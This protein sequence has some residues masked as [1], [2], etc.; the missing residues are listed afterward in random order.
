MVP[1][2]GMGNRRFAIDFH[3][4]IVPGVD[5][6]ARSLE[7]SL[8]AVERMVGE[9][10]GGICTTPHLN[11]SITHNPVRL[12]QRLNKVN[13]AWEKVSSVVKDSFPQLELWS[14]YEIMLDIPDPNL[15][16]LRL[17]LAGTPFVL[18]EWPRLQIPPR[19]EQVISKI[20]ADGYLPIIAHPERYEG[21]RRNIDIAGS[22]RRAGAYLQVSCGSFVDRYGKEVKEAAFDFLARGWVDYLSSDFHARRHLSIHFNDVKDLFHD[23]DG[24]E[25]IKLL[26]MSNPRRMLLGEAPLPVPELVIKQ[27]LLDRFK[28][29]FKG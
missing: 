17:R 2:M 9:G 16:D 10:I 22:W 27:R 11:A 3:N 12:E 26:T 4:H 1:E 15:S 24:Y 25:Q 21:I 8:E 13:D 23:N 6:G 29:I 18:I 5:D 20:C 28:N 7:E 14:G 19:T